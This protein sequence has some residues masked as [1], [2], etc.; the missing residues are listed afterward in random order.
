MGKNEN[1]VKL[2]EFFQQVEKWQNDEDW[3]GE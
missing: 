1:D 2:W 3:G